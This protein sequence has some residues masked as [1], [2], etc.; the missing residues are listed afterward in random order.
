MG[1]TASGVHPLDNLQLVLMVVVVDALIR[2]ALSVRNGDDS[3]V[4]RRRVLVFVPIGAGARGGG[5]LASLEVRKRAIH[6]ISGDGGDHA[7]VG[8]S[9]DDAAERPNRNGGGADGRP[10]FLP[11]GAKCALAPQKSKMPSSWGPRG[12]PGGFF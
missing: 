12:S 2:P 3:R 4:R 5:G 1:A 8:V 7:R 9:G 6:G 10:H 11:D